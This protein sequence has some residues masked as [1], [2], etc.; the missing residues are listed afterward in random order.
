MTRIERTRDIPSDQWEAS[1]KPN[2]IHKNRD[3]VITIWVKKIK[4]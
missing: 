1:T 3:E 2:R 4:Q